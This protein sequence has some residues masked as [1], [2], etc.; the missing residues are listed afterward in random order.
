MSTGQAIGGVVGAAA[1]FVLSGGNPA[2][3]LYGAQAGMMA[4][5]YLDPPKGPTIEGPRLSD[6]SVQTSTYGAFIPRLYGTVGM[7][8][9][10]FWLENNKLK[11]VVKKKK[12]GGKGGGGGT[13]TKTYSYFATLAIGV[14]EGPVDAIKKI[15]AGPTLVY[16]SGSSDLG[17]IIA[18]NKATSNFAIYYG[19]DTQLPDSR[20]QAEMGAGNT[21]AYRGLCYVVIKDFAL[22]KYGNAIPPFRFEVVK[23]GSAVQPAYVQTIP[24]YLGEICYSDESIFQ[25]FEETG[26]FYGPTTWTAE[27]IFRTY[28]H[29]GALVKQQTLSDT[30]PLA[31]GNNDNPVWHKCGAFRG[32]KDSMWMHRVT[33]TATIK[34]RDTGNQTAYS[35]SGINSG[36]CFTACADGDYYICPRGSGTDVID[37]FGNKVTVTG[38]FGS[39]SFGGMCFA[40]DK[41]TGRVYCRW[42]DS[43]TSAARLGELDLQAGVLLWYVTLSPN[44]SGG[45]ATN[46]N[47]FVAS[48]GLIAIESGNALRIYTG[49]GVAVSSETGSANNIYEFAPGHFVRASKDVY[50]MTRRDGHVETPIADVVLSEIAETGLLSSGDV[51]VS[52]LTD[53]LTGYRIGKISSIRSAI[54]PL[55]GAFPFDAIQS[56]YK[57]KFKK[58]GGSAVRSVVIGDLGVDK[59]LEQS[60]DMDSQLPHKLSLSYLDNGRNYDANGYVAERPT[61]GAVNTKNM[62]LPIVLTASQAAQVAEK[63]VNLY[64]LERVTFGPFTLPPTFCDLEP[65]DIVTLDAGYASYELR[66]TQINY[67]SDGSLECLAKLNNSATYTSTAVGTPTP[68]DSVVEL[69]GTSAYQLIDMPVI[70][71][72]LQNSPGIMAAMAGYTSGWSGGTIFRS[73]DSG[74]TWDDV[75]GFTAAA[76]IGVAVNALTQHDGN[77]IQQGGSLTVSLLDGDLSSVTEAQMLNGANMAAYGADGRW[78]VVRFQTATL[79]GDGTYTLSQFW[80]GD[81]GT[82]W[83]TGLHQGG[84][85]FVLLNDPDGAW[86]SMALESIGAPRVYRGISSGNTLDSDTDLPFTYVGANLKPYSPV[87]AKGVRSAGDLTMTWTRRTRIGGAWLD[88]VDAQLG[89]ASE[90]YQID[91]MAGSTVKRTISASTQTA[92]YTSADQVTDFG[93][94]QASIT[95][96]IYQLSATVGRGYPL[97]VTL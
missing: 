28:T 58:R 41:S 61:T 40:E 38:W 85:A 69:N 46:F 65:A 21:P 66:I 63:L 57:I 74:Q 33:G 32:K 7:N 5:G 42:S 17:S 13:T 36:N 96:R 56:G 15:W 54:E 71:E 55:Q 18:S 77:I 53:T 31:D 24:S 84:D 59:Q 91:V 47:K 88:S 43:S 67:K 76:T 1:G 80:R 87:N 82:E 86:V 49:D 50:Q 3:A 19:S 78:E 30:M 51:D 79:N 39:P 52:S 89:E 97:E 81:R 9:N 22:E 44:S 16:D 90:A 20:M 94:A 35:I 95:V 27:V 25:T 8:G 6:L 23:N 4:G 12:S 70:D 75:Q 72:S 68:D 2:I 14:C 45:W 11:E 83:A 92:T 60:R 34:I 48:N 29:N 73:A 64:W 26:G 62:D 37:R 10:I 93:S